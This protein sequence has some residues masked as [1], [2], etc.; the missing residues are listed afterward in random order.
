MNYL[1]VHLLLSQRVC[2]CVFVF[3]CE[4]SVKINSQL[5]FFTSCFLI[6]IYFPFLPFPSLFSSLSFFL[7]SSPFFFV[8]IHSSFHNLHSFVTCFAFLSFS[9]SSSFLF[10]SL[11]CFF[12]LFSHNFFLCFP[13][14]SHFLF[15]T[16]ASFPFLPPPF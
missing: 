3:S 15:F 5:P 11:F 2:V 14:S 6:F 12:T 7:F 10:F 4:R 9:L 8:P 13:F 16:S 1:S